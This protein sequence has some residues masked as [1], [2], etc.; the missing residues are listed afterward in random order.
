MSSCMCVCTF[1]HGMLLVTFPVQFFL[2]T[3]TVPSTL[4]YNGVISILLQYLVVQK[5]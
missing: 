2:D 5:T 3:F 1:L 4:N